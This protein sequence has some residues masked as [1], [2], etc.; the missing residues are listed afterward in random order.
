[1]FYHKLQNAPIIFYLPLG[2]A[3][4]FILR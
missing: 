2:S 4:V 3:F 1:M